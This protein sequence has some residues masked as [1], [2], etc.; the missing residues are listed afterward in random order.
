MKFL[1]KAQLKDDITEQDFD[2]GYVQGSSAVIIRSRVDL[3]ELWD[4]LRK[5]ANTMLWCNGMSCQPCSSTSYKRAL[6]EAMSDNEEVETRKR[7]KKKRKKVEDDRAAE[8]DET[9][10]ILKEQIKKTTQTM[11]LD[12]RITLLIE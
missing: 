12:S 1:I 4:T 6:S 11:R 9:V 3:E 5:G 8:V 10:E 2:V 7:K